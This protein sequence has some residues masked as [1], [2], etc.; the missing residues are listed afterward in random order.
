MASTY[1]ALQEEKDGKG[2]A[3]KVK[4][5]GGE[6]MEFQMDMEDSV[7][8]LKK[9]IEAKKPAA[10]LN[11][12][13]LIWM[14]REINDGKAKLGVVFKDAQNANIAIHLVIRKGDATNRPVPSSGAAAPIAM[15]QPSRP[16]QTVK[17]PF[18]RITVQFP[19]GSQMIVAA[20]AGGYLGYNVQKAGNGSV[21]NVAAM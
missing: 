20:I 3:I 16:M 4:E 12:Q 13:R 6:E 21:P 15:A 19:E 8:D 9:L 11:R 14:G 2:Y 1:A 7:M 18:C 5:L 10:V 17:C